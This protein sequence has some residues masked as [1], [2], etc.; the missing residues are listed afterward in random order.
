MIKPDK[1][2]LGCRPGSLRNVPV[3]YRTSSHVEV[4]F[5]NHKFQAER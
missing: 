4:P 1:L 2:D 5:S 3:E